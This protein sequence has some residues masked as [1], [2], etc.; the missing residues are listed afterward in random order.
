MKTKQ[1]TILQQWLC[2]KYTKVKLVLGVGVANLLVSVPAFAEP[3]AK[4][5]TS[6]VLGDWIA[7]I[8]A[9]IVVAIVIKMFVNQDWVKAA[10]LFVA[11]AIVYFF[12]K[13]PQAFLD[14]LN[15]FPTKFGF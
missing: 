15:T 12:I 6:Y 4:G 14:A 5:A 3:T 13:D 8:F 11:G 2:G 1:W 10:M 9:V 7:P